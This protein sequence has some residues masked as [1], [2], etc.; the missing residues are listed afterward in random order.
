MK[1]IIK[2]I[3]LLYLFIEIYSDCDPEL[4][5][6]KVRNAKDCIERS[7]TEEEI[8]DKSFKCCHIKRIIDSI[9]YKGE[10]HKCV[11]LTTY[12]YENIQKTII[13]YQNSNDIKEVKIDCYTPFISFNLFYIFI[14]FL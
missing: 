14:L 5:T 3:L 9:S 4:E 8:E 12:E 2:S 13:S 6:V 10:E 1:L 7:F 11:A